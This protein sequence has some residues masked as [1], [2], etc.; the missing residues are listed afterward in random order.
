MVQV[1][2]AT[3]DVVWTQGVDISVG[4]R[5]RRN[6]IYM[7]G[8]LALVCVAGFVAIGTN[9]ENSIKK[10]AEES[11]LTS[12]AYV[13]RN[14]VKP[15]IYRFD[16]VSNAITDERRLPHVWDMVW[17]NAGWL[18]KKLMVDK[19][20]SE[21]KYIGLKERLQGTSLAQIQQ[22]H[23][24]K[25][26][27]M[28]SVGGGWL[29]HGDTFPLNTFGSG[30]M[31]PNDGKMT[32]YDDRFPCLMSG[33]AEEW[34]RIATI[35]VEHAEKYASPE[36]WT[37]QKAL[38]DIENEIKTVSEVFNVQDAGE[39]GKTWTWNSKDCS[40]T[41]NMRAVHFLVDF[42]ED[43]SQIVDPAD[44]VVKWLS[45]WLQACERSTVFADQQMS[46]GRRTIQERSE[47]ESEGTVNDVNAIGFAGKALR[48]K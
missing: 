7:I 12:L 5:S 2:A 36:G 23:I 10:S 38:S 43:L 6:M 13:K 21:E 26:L 14:S 37:E 24:H 42:L 47:S 31:L 11:S 25:Y 44:M 28:A 27:A 18:P 15:V 45:M 32:V 46:G 35:L 4:S 3:P 33:S 39:E 30:A 9:K 40:L 16:R 19:L 17:S 29:G 41:K 48:V 20:S 22:R 1:N 34:M 8:A